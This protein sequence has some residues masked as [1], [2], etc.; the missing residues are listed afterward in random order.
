MSQQ[1][2]LRLGRSGTLRVGAAALLGV[3]LVALLVVRLVGASHAVSK[4]QRSALVGHAAPDFTI[5]AW[6]GV[7][8]QTIHLAALRGQPVVLNFWATW[9]D[10]CNAEAPLLQAAWE[11]YHSRGVVFIGVAVDTQQADGMQFLLHYGIS[12]LCGPD[13]GADLAVPYGLV[14]LPATIFIDARGIVADKVNIQL[15]SAKLAHGL[16]ALGEKPAA[17][18]HP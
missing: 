6:N 7:A 12:Y 10:P 1:F 15:D 16:A 11:Q 17:V 14:G 18:S 2:S 13:P 4:A 5:A 8:N 3:A 9:C